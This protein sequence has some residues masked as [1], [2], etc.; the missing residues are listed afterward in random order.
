MRDWS[1]VFFMLAPLCSLAQA[2]GAVARRCRFAWTG[3]WPAHNAL[4]HV[5]GCSLYVLAL[6][7]VA[8]VTL[9]SCGLDT[10]YTLSPPTEVHTPTY[11]ADDDNQKYFVFQT[12][13]TS[14]SSEGDFTFDGTELYYKI[15]DNTSVM[16][17]ADAAISSRNSSTDYSAAA[18][19]MI[20]TLGYQRFKLSSGSIIPLIKNTGTSRYVYIR[21]SD[22]NYNTSSSEYSYK[23]GIC[24]TG[25]PSIHEYDSSTS[26]M[27]GETPV[28][29]TRSVDSSYT[30]NFDGQDREKDRVPESGDSD[31]N[32]SSSKTE[33]GVWYVNLYAVSVGRDQYFTTSYSQVLHLGSVSIKEGESKHN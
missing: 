2:A 9:C 17:N 25:N 6:C 12:N 18:S 5:Q 11:I 31:V 21:L 32:Y 15:Y 30:F 22:V 3:R 26:L 7:C 27:Y 13:E 8:V 19:Y 23:K 14:N 28:F 24:I 29:L 20:D 1:G 10:I 33:S 4:F 16:A